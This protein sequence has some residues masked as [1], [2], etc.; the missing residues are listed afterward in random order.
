MTT[1]PGPRTGAPTAQGGTAPGGHLP[2]GTSLL[3]HAESLRTQADRLRAAVASLAWTGPDADALR[4]RVTT[5]AARCDTA[6]T[7]L[8]RGADR[9]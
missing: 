9:A 3:A 6:A 1:F 7:A 5:L 4:A 8:A 2:P